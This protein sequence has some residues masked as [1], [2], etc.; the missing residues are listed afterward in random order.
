MTLLVQLFSSLGLYSSPIE[1]E[2]L[3]LVW[4]VGWFNK[5]QKLGSLNAPLSIFISDGKSFAFSLDKLTD[6]EGVSKL[7]DSPTGMWSPTTF[8]TKSTTLP[9]FCSW[10]TTFIFFNDIFIL[11]FLVF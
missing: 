5:S 7:N 6:N 3:V 2:A 10:S 8:V 9:D 4:V 11:L 1:F